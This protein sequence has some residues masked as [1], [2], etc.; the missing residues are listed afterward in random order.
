MECRAGC[1]GSRGVRDPGEAGP[2][3]LEE[4]PDPEPSVSV[5]S[6]NRCRPEYLPGL[7]P[8]ET[9]GTRQLTDNLSEIIEGKINMNALFTT[10]IWGLVIKSSETEKE[11]QDLVSE[12][13]KEIG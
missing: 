5:H 9:W 13:S 1:P 3:T 10:R 11:I 12:V 4:P 2:F 6:V 8:R 7:G